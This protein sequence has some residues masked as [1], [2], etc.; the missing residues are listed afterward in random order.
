VYRAQRVLVVVAERWPEQRHVDAEG[1]LLHG[2]RVADLVA[3]EI[4]GLP[5]HLRVV[6]R[7]VLDDPAGRLHLFEERRT[8]H[9]DR[10]LQEHGEPDVRRLHQLDALGQLGEAVVHGQKRHGLGHREAVVDRRERAV[11]YRY[12]LRYRGRT[13]LRY[14]RQ[15]RIGARLARR[16]S[17]RQ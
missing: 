11:R 16:R 6:D 3:L 8:L 10:G 1:V 13:E 4:V 9:G 5:L 7:V 12:R 17:G 14:L 15:V 2:A